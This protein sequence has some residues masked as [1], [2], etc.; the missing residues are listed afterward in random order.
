MHVIWAWLPLSSRV[1]LRPID[2]RPTLRRPKQAAS[3]TR[4]RSSFDVRVR[5]FRTASE[6]SV[7]QIFQRRSRG[8]GRHLL[9]QQ[10]VLLRDPFIKTRR[11]CVRDVP[12]LLVGAGDFNP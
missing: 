4:A 7:D 9:S 10:P 5:P 6:P 8:P 3:R 12:R 11:E 2:P 1:A